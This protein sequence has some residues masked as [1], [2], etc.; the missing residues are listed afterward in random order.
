[1]FVIQRL[2]ERWFLVFEN[3]K[4]IPIMSGESHKSNPNLLTRQ[5]DFTDSQVKL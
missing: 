1:M 2:S 5:W 3:S 4:K